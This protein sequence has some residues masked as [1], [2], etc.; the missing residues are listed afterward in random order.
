MQSDLASKYAN[1]KP[2]EL[3]DLN[4]N[5]ESSLKKKFSIDEKIFLSANVQKYNKRDK[6]QMRG[7]LVTNK[8]VYNLAQSGT[9]G[10]MF[11]GGYT[12]KRKI[13]ISKISA[14]S[15]SVSDIGQEFVIHVN[16][17]Y[18]Y[19]YASTDK[20]EPILLMIARAYYLNPGSKPLGFFLT[21]KANLRE[22]TTTE[23][24]MKKK[25][26]RMPKETPKQMN[27][28]ELATYFGE[29]VKKRQ[30]L[31]AQTQAVFSKPNSALS[32]VTLEDFELIKVLGRGAFGKVML[33]E[34]KD[35]KL[36]YALKSMR[37][38]D[39]IEKDQI[40]HTKTERYVLERSDSPFLVALEYAFQNPEKIFFVMRFMKGGELFQHLR[41]AKRFD[42][43]RAKFYAA[44]ITL[45]IEH[46]HKMDVIYRDLKP[47][48]ILMDEDGH[49]CLTDFGMAK[50]VRD[51]QLT[52]SFVGTPEYLAPEIIENK[53]HSKPVDWWSLGIL[54]YEMIIGLPPFYNREQNQS[55]MFKW[56]REKDVTFAS[57][58]P[59]TDDAKDLILSLLIKNPDKRLGTKGGDEIRNHKWFKDIDWKNLAEKK[60]TP[61]FK[62]KV[63]GDYDVDNF[64]EE[65]TSEDPINSMVDGNMKLVNKYQGEFEG[66]TFVGTNPLL[67][68]D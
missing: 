30:E 44:E 21:E 65:F 56:I 63:T 9:L 13:D 64:D 40:E 2:E 1:L 26:Q 12:I 35:T 17:E 8:A 6:R 18:D 32:K 14:I 16:D 33:V 52:T 20:K 66:M 51:G 22:F 7:L 4:I 36:V 46:L 11:G 45:A 29:K 3:D 59:I 61:P 24:D 10:K 39:I 47:E 42:E 60:L 58:V 38:E 54:I 68:K 15:V 5:K 31:S 67:S 62:P 55:L 19:R 27:E 53:G 43:N 28:T 48:N 41:Q 37:K 49:V 23:D 34:K 50:I 25:V 57:K